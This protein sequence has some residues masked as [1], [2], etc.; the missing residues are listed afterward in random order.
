MTALIIK[1]VIMKSSIGHKHKKWII[2]YLEMVGKTF[3]RNIYR[4]EANNFSICQIRNRKNLKMITFTSILIK[5][6]F[7]FGSERIWISLTRF[8]LALVVNI[9]RQKLLPRLLRNSWVFQSFLKACR[10][11]KKCH[12]KYCT[13]YKYFL[14]KFNHK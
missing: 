8:A 10:L 7:F 2:R 12:S 1:K 3:S 11:Q 14:N 9:Y 6:T 4:Y 13:S 5:N